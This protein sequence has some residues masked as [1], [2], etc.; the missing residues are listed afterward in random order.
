LFDTLDDQPQIEGEREKPQNEVEREKLQF[1]QDYGNME[2]T[3]SETSIGFE[4]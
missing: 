3:S 1:F 4:R 2:T